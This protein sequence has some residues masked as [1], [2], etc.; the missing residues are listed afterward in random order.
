MQLT[1]P[2]ILVDT[3]YQLN[4]TKLSHLCMNPGHEPGTVGNDHHPHGCGC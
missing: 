1:K 4:G 3:G 2:D